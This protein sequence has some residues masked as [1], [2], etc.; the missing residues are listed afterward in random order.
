MVCVWVDDMRCVCMCAGGS[1][2]VSCSMLS[3]AYVSGSLSDKVGHTPLLLTL[4]RVLL[5]SV[6][7]CVH[8][9]SSPPHK[10][11]YRYKA[12]TAAGGSDVKEHLLDDSTDELWAE[13]R[14]A[15]IAGEVCLGGCMYGAY[16]CGARCMGHA[17]LV[18]HGDQ[19]RSTVV[20][21]CGIGAW[22]HARLSLQT[23]ASHR[24]G[25]HGWCVFVTGCV[26]RKN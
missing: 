5:P 2:S 7:V 19:P 15:H 4:T 6:C 22:G 25:Q 14:H 21:V 18:P 9:A 20:R 3:D 8:M 12:E 16:I 17:H 24:T 1:N 23:G 11:T 13:L 26:H 10:H